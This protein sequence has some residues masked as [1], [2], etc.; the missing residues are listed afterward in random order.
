MLVA[1]FTP[2]RDRGDLIRVA[3][4]AIMTLQ[5]GSPMGVHRASSL[6]MIMAGFMAGCSQAES[7]DNPDGEPIP[8][9]AVVEDMAAVEPTSEDVT[10]EPTKADRSEPKAE[11]TKAEPEEPVAEPEAHPV[12]PDVPPAPRVFASAGTEMT[13]RLEQ[14]LSTKSAQPGDRFHATLIED[15][16]SGDG[17]ILVPLGS[18]VRGVVV[19][20]RESQGSDKP[21][22]L[23]LRLEVLDM[24]GSTQPLEATIVASDAS[25][26]TRD[27]DGTTAVKVAAGTAAGALL[28]RVIGGDSKGTLIGAGA[29]AVAGTVYAVTTKDGHAEMDEGAILTVRLDEPLPI[30]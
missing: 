28:G 18:I 1:S 16:L 7:K 5:G 6:L 27:S 12:E 22:V 13:F 2:A 17:A 3:Q 19:E 15:V 9:V 23:D 21:P 4:R 10:P 8:P 29:G 30:G 25:S 24:H 14:S 11:P 26:E 20:S